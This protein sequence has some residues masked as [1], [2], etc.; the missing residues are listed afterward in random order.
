MESECCCNLLTKNYMTQTNNKNTC[1]KDSAMNT[2]LQATRLNNSGVGFLDS[3]DVARAIKEFERAAEVVTVSGHGVV[4]TTKDPF[5][6]VQYQALPSRLLGL[7]GDF[8]IYDRPIN[9]VTI[10]KTKEGCDRRDPCARIST[11][12]V[13]AFNFALACHQYG[14]CVGRDGGL[15]RAIELYGF[16]MRILNSAP[17]SQNQRGSNLLKCLSLNNMAQIFEERCCYNECFFALETLKDL[18]NL[19]NCLQ[20]SHLEPWEI[21]HVALNL[22][23]QPPTGAHMA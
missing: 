23:Y 22:M 20:Q 5:F 1:F 6:D 19:S 16:S 8:Y 13:I 17:D 9:I 15:N 11:S 2:L 21:A 12:A 10:M 18:A 14:L 4:V 3:G 7:Q